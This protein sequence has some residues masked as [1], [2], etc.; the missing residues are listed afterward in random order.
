[1]ISRAKL[2]A[3]IISFAVALIVIAMLLPEQRSSSSALS[4][5]YT[6]QS[7]SHKISQPN[8]P[9][10]E[11]MERGVLRVATRNA[12]TTYYQGAIGAE[13]FEFDLVKDFSDYLGVDLEVVLYDSVADILEAV[14]DGDV[15]LAAAGITKTRGRE[16]RFLFGPAYQQI[17]QQVVCNRQQPAPQKIADLVGRDLNVIAGSSYVERLKQLATEHTALLWTEH[18]QVSTEE[19][20]YS[21]A[22]GQIECVV[23]DSNIVRLNQRYFPDVRQALTLSDKQSLA[24]AMHQRSTDLK[25]VI[26]DWFLQYQELGLLE[27]LDQHY[28]QYVPV[29]DFVDTRAFHRRVDSRLP[30]YQPF[31]EQSA[32]Q[33]E[34]GWVLLAAQ[35]YQESHWNP[36]A[37]SPTGV[38]GMMMLTLPTAKQVGIKSRLDAE[39]SIDGGARYMASLLGRLPEDIPQK[40]RIWYGLAAYNIGMGHLYD[41]RN[42]AE[43]LGK[44]P[45]NWD[46]M[47]QVLPLLAKKKYYS[48]LRYGYARGYEP[49]EY[50]KRVRHYRDILTIKVYP[51]NTA[52]PA[53]ASEPAAAPSD[54]KKQP[55]EGAETDQASTD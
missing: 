30:H 2:I 20:I 50:V 29:F 12:P 48:R 31:F 53:T 42:L 33:N 46:D 45:N 27:K 28:Y 44:D 24:W 6:K 25:Q 11:I 17:E 15:D 19:L 52:F 8:S 54:D 22:Q 16:S 37:K 47:Q 35:S 40:D 3:I 18:Q 13:G 41:A 5:V 14:E 39:Q 38:R 36:K 9:V 34:L 51:E 43:S 7:S 49:V 4:R 32:Q 1:M 55:E 23:S 10:T 26:A 21:A